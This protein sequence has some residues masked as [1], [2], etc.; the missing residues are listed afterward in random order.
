MDKLKVRLESVL[1]ETGFKLATTEIAYDGN[2]RQWPVRSVS[3]TELREICSASEARVVKRSVRGV[4]PEAPM[5]QLVETLRRVL[6]RFVDPESDRIGHAFFIESG[7]SARVTGQDDGLYVV[8]FASPLEDFAGA[9]LQ[10]AAIDGVEKIVALL[11][12][13]IS[14]EPVRVRLSTVL[15]GLYLDGAVLPLD[16]VEVLPLP[17]TTAELP[18]LPYDLNRT[19]LDYLG[20]TRLTLHLSA[21]PA[22]F[23]PAGNRTGGAVKFA[24][25]GGVDFGLVCEALSLE[26]DG[27]VD[28]G[29]CWHE[30]P[31]AMAFSLGPP[32]PWSP[33]TKGLKALYW[34]SLEMHDGTGGATITPL[35]DRSIRSL[36]SAEVGRTLEALRQADRKRRIAVDRWRRS[37]REEIRLEDRYIELRIALETLY[38][39][40][41]ANEHSQEMRF[42]LALFGAWHLGKDLEQRK[43]IRKTLRD[44]Y[45]TAS[46]AVHTGEVP[47]AEAKGLTDAQSLCRRGIQKLLHEG[48]PADWGNMVLGG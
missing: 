36:D 28:W 15:D 3:P 32:N 24:S 9:V 11:G 21:G 20:K 2:S 22:L 43:S 29:G 17:L 39:K 8:E 40:D 41:F 6:E 1:A 35:H 38:L 25:N 34:R 37:K 7:F 19:P 10:A 48:P 45:D 5:R 14:G 44:A 16:D 42:R 33:G 4:P 18:P 31:D 27:C 47:A 30:F 46:K 23:R 26:S 13:W 12:D